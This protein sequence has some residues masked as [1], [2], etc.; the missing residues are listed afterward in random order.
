[1]LNSGN[2]CIVVAPQCPAASAWVADGYYPGSAA[3]S[4]EDPMGEYLAA[5]KELLDNVI[6]TAAVDTKR[7]YVCGSSNGA[8]ASWELISRFPDLFAAGVPM[9]GCPDASDAAAIA[10][11]LKATPIWTFHGD[12]DATLSV[13]GTRGLVAAIQAAGG[14]KIQ[15]TEISGGTHDIWL[16]ASA[17]EGLSEWL[18]AQERDLS[19]G[20]SEK[21][22]SQ[23]HISVNGKMLHIVADHLT[24]ISVYTVSGAKLFQTAVQGEQF[25][26]LANGV[27]IIETNQGIS[28]III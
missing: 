24:D 9:A 21:L 5:A 12:A 19:A 26:P 13:E 4:V 17:T 27:Y 8:G 3:Y 23:I 7:I 1:M 18:F 10:D 22:S 2:E 6:N 15:Y 28:K 25:F 16:Q 20:I 14:T 11:A